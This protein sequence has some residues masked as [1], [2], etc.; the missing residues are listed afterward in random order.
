MNQSTAEKLI[1]AV[2]ANT[3]ALVALRESLNVPRKASRSS[4]R[5]NA[6][7]TVLEFFKRPGIVRRRL[8][9][10]ATALNKPD[11]TVQWALGQ[12]TDAGLLVREEA[13]NTTLYSTPEAL[14][15]F[16][17]L[18]AQGQ[19]DAMLYAEL[20]SRFCRPDKWEGGGRAYD[21]GLAALFPGVDVPA[22]L[23]RLE[24]AGK[25]TRTDGKIVRPEVKP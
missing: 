22:A 18:D 12:L 4:P 14:D 21:V 3:S 15:E 5:G 11:R 13:G 23:A 24:A 25:L 9:P 8:L 16:N 17:I 19:A 7:E 1:A 10:T 2:E 6:K 20:L